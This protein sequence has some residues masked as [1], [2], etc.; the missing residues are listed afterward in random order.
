MQAQANY[1]RP[2]YF[3]ELIKVQLTKHKGKSMRL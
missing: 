2:L 3:T 1:R